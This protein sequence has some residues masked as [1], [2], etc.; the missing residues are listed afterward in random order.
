MISKKILVCVISVLIAF[1]V[2]SPVCTFAADTETEKFVCVGKYFNTLLNDGGTT[3]YGVI[4]QPNITAQEFIKGTSNNVTVYS[5]DGKKADEQ[6]ILR[7]G[8]NFEY[9]CGNVKSTAIIVVQG[10]VNCDGF[11]QAA[12]ARLA[13]R[14]AVKLEV[15]EDYKKAAAD[16]NEPSASLT[17]NAADARL[18]LRAAVKLDNLTVADVAIS[19]SHTYSTS[20]IVQK[21]TCVD[22]G[23]ELFSCV[24]GASK[25]EKIAATD[26]HNF[27][28]SETK[29]VTCNSDGQTVYK[30][31]VC[32]FKKTETESRYTIDKATVTQ[33]KICK[34]CGEI[35]ELA[36]N[37]YVNSIKQ[38]KHTLAYVKTAVDKSQI[39][40]D[41]LKYNI[42][43]AATYLMED[44]ENQS[45]AE[46][47]DELYANINY[48]TETNGTF[49]ADILLNNYN[50]PVSD[51]ELV[52]QLEDSDVVSY[53]IEE[54]ESVDFRAFLP[55]SYLKTGGNMPVDISSYIYREID[56]LIKLTVVL[57]TENYEDIKNNNEQTALTKIGGTDIRELYAK[58]SGSAEQ[59]FA[60]SGSDMFSCDKF[61]SDATVVYYID[62]AN[63]NAPVAAYY[64]ENC[65]GNWKISLEAMKCGSLSFSTEF[66][67]RNFYFFDN[68]FG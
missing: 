3:F 45:A 8:M 6:T 38:N 14:S 29:K 25:T 60:T 7:T 42:I 58:M 4:V 64:Y 1:S 43:S 50:L 47:K 28:V 56:N 17:V 26:K 55:T 5:S 30:C 9:L 32:G 39:T 11:V 18:I 62:A 67:K 68:Y 41:T 16:V 49:R 36:F 63:D 54:V 61:T 15:L 52:S 24:C 53:K 22:D 40:Q 51:S 65:V 44:V 34:S 13:L 12:D 46:I 48:T 2:F 10:D 23:K 57:K 37:D 33:S 59:S 66:I 19:H 20:G 35:I 27:V 21:P 31:S